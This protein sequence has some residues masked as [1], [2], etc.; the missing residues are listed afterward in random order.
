MLE[1]NVNKCS[2][3]HIGRDN[4]R[5][6]Y[7][8]GNSILSVRDS[9][10]DL[11]ILVDSRLTFQPH[12]FA[13]VTRARSRCAVFLKSFVSRDKSIMRTFFVH[14]VR[15]ILEYG[16]V[17]W[18]PIS[19]P[20]IARL[21]GVQRWFT[22]KIRGCHLLSYPSR[23]QF[24]GLQS[25]QSRRVIADIIFIFKMLRGEVAIDIGPH[26][27]LREPGITRGHQSK[28]VQPKFRLSSSKRGLFARSIKLWNELPAHLLA[29]PS[30]HSF[31]FALTAYLKEGI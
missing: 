31:R 13:L 20:A 18:S 21:E 19:E 30:V 4:L 27:Q 3:L 25:L 24:I 16:S 2:V 8:L 15:P 14:Y 1:L 29:S 17:V 12:I 5:F 11:G 6:G 26:L 7:Q 23:L 22:K 10:P 9:V 28:I